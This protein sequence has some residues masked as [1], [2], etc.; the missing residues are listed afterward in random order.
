M[1][2]ALHE[3]LPAGG[4]LDLIEKEMDGF[5]AALVRVEAV[6][7]A[8]NK[9][10]IARAEL[11]EPVVLEVDKDKVF[12]R[13][14]PIQTKTLPGACRGTRLLRTK[15]WPMRACPSAIKFWRLSSSIS[16][17]FLA[18]T[19]INGRNSNHFSW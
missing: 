19:M 1:E 10:K 13:R 9:V 16:A 4:F 5:R 12:P 2:H 18:D 3:K 6:A 8:G 7:G 17:S 14:G 11:L 15:G